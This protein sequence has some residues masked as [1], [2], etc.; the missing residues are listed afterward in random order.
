M[1]VVGSS[2]MGGY[3]VVGLRVGGYGSDSG[4][5]EKDGWLGIGWW[6]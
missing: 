3:R 2:G 6:G 1:V 5:G 4:S